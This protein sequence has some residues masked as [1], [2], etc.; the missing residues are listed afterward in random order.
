[1]TDVPER[2]IEHAFSWTSMRRW[3]WPKE[4]RK[5][6]QVIDDVA[7]VDRIMHHVPESRRRVAVQAGGATGVWA[8]RLAYEFEEVWTFE[9]LRQNWAALKF[10]VDTFRRRKDPKAKGFIYATFG[11]LGGR[12]GSA[13]SVIMQ[14]HPNEEANA[15]SY[16]VVPVR[17]EDCDDVENTSAMFS[18]D[19]FFSPESSKLPVDLLCLDVEGYE[20]PALQGG[21]NVIQH[22]RPVV[23]V[24]DKGLSQRYGYQKGDVI[25]WLRSRGYVVAEKI[26]RDV[27]LV[28]AQDGPLP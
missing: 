14:Q 23:V 28:H 20:L 26:K 9:P 19:G 27:V 15:G 17:S 4:D 5:L 18:V 6:L 22:H 24:E 3:A 2:F 25:Q 12:D 10:N 21:E 8:C 13:D 7:D 1:M 16:Q 11:A